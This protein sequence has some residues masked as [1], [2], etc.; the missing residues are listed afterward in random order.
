MM[1]FLS[2]L[3]C[4][5]AVQSPTGSPPSAPA[6]ERNAVAIDGEPIAWTEMAA[7]LVRFQG[8]FNAPAFRRAYLVH[9]AAVKLGLSPSKEEVDLAVEAKIDERVASAFGGDRS[10]WLEE[11]KLLSLSEQSY[12]AQRDID[13]RYEIELERLIIASRIV[14]DEE[15]R[16]EWERLYGLNG[17]TLSLRKIAI[18][19]PYPV[20]MPGEEPEESTRKREKVEAETI[21]RAR[22]L[23]KDILA[24]ADF[25]D[26]ARKESDD[27]ETRAAGGRMKEG[28]VA[29][30]WPEAALQAIY[31]L[32]QDEITEPI[33]A[34]GKV[35]LFQLLAAKNTP[36]A[37]VRDDVK[38]SLAARKPIVTEVNRFLEQ[39]LN[40]P[41]QTFDEMSA[42]GGAKRMDEPVMQVAGTPITRRELGQWL[43]LRLGQT[44]SIDFV[45][46]RL[47]EQLA[48]EFGFTVTEEEID[49]RVRADLDIKVEFM[50]K[51][52]VENW[53]AD[54]ER[55]GHTRKMYEN[56]ASVRARIDLLAEKILRSQRKISEEELRD[57]WIE[58]YGPGGRQ[59][60]VRLILKKIR[61]PE[62]E[63]EITKDEFKRIQDQAIAD[64]KTET[65][66]IRER[67]EDGEDFAALARRV[68]DDERTREAGGTLDAAFNSMPWPAEFTDAIDKTGVGNLT[69]PL[70]DAGAWYLF[71]VL[72]DAT[73]AFDSVREKLLEQVKMRR[74]DSVLV[75]GF[76]NT[77]LQQ[78]QFEVLPGMFR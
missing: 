9:E 52:E 75:S 3:L 63:G 12:R 17:R 29:R 72:S 23:R 65:E 10:K 59:V 40:G 18:D 66:R 67:I 61:L 30:G 19:V 77:T 51:G 4:A 60:L 1:K 37:S 13:S 69:D 8:E 56:Q 34:F 74:P 71:E 25:G 24:G 28:F 62:I 57:A 39:L 68:S 5:F 21:A 6:N 7:W 38:A 31:G 49:E 64:A 11:L 53:E 14:T 27:A 35:H 70:Y 44:L 46:H 50:F 36:L 41:V 15:I 2:L 42:D 78:H 33:Y 16:T 20:R 54:L 22:K 55:R 48:A 43:S 76:M 32:A 73:V 47:I 45:Q 26:V 58:E